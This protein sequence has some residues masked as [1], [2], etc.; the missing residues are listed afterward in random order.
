[1]PV[2]DGFETLLEGFKRRSVVVP[3]TFVVLV[4][5]RELCEGEEGL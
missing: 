3:D 4:P 1:M 2:E 5:V